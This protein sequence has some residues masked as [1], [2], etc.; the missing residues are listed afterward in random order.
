MIS[1]VFA[2]VAILALFLIA[3][4]AAFE[5]YFS[6]DDLDN[7]SW[8]T[9]AGID[10]FVSELIT[11][12][13]SKTNTR[14]TGGL[15]YRWAGHAWQWQ[16][17]RYLIPLFALHWLNSV[18]I[19]L[20][21][22]RKDIPEFPAAVATLFFL[23]HS[24]LLEAWWKPMYIFDLLAATFCLLTWLL[25]GTRLW[26]AAIITF[27][28]AYKS[29]E[30]A[31]F[32]SIVLALEN[33]RRAIPF[34]LI[35]ASFGLQAMQVNTKRDTVYT[36]R[37]TPKALLTTIPFYGKQFL[38]NKFGALLVAPIL[39]FA[40]QR[41]VW[42]SFAGAA[43]LCIPLL[44][45]PGRLF[46]VYLYVPMLALM[47]GL[48]AIFKQIPKRSLAAG[49]IAFIALDYISLKEKR[50]LEL[51]SGHETR[52]YISQ[53]QAAAPIEAIAYFENSPLNFRLHGM[54]GALRL[55]TKNPNAKV[56]NPEVE[57]N[58]L[59]AKGKELPTFHWFAP[60][61]KLTIANHQFGE[62]KRSE[63]EFKDPSSA[64]QLVEGWFDREGHFRWAAPN[65]RL[66]LRAAKDHT[67]LRVQFNN[68]PV[69][70]NAVK[71][72]NVTIRINGEE[73]GEAAFTTAGTP[74]IDFPLKH[75]IEGPAQIKFLSKPGYLP[76]GDDRTL[77]V[78]IIS[79]A[80]IR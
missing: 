6:D 61:Q 5:G 9:V 76:P 58:R 8:A 62:A 68:G 60:K 74:I 54:T 77:G 57:A 63:L 13:F 52:S 40:R 80:L 73:L 71:Q 19:F 75:S 17:E 35:S 18:L 29:K 36:L 32:F 23:F 64:W 43:A 45:L 12:V 79:V 26:I 11:P 55:I 66:N 3:N 28:L 49:L 70:M 16:F 59:E 15:F 33:W 78:A 38:L 30:V 69:F 56:L 39:L 24:A 4:R 31:L 48:A 27:W 22:R 25:Y 67:R 47:P 50:K 1:R 34:L 21:L 53:L 51:A 41:E 10:S 20:L 72:L 14:P 37:F 46:S 42:I 65:A 2:I 7:L 44:F